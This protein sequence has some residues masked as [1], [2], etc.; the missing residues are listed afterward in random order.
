MMCGQGAM[1]FTDGSQFIGKWKDD[2]IDGKYIFIDSD[3]EKEVVVIR[4]N[5]IVERGK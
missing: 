3:G 4:D 5:Q 1:F 2:M